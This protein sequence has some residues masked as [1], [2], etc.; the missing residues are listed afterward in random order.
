MTKKQQLTNFAQEQLGFYVYALRNPID[1]KIFYIGKGQGSRVL[2]H[3]NDVLENPD[4]EDSFKRQTIKAIHDAGR[5]VESFIVQHGLESEDHAFATESAI[6]GTLKLLQDGLDHSQFTLTNK[7][8]PPSFNE[9]GLR[10]LEEVLDDYGQPADSSLIPHNSLLIKSTEAGTWKRGMTRDQVWESIRGWW[11]L[12]R[13]RLEN[14]KYV[15]AIPDFVIR[16]VWEVKPSDW[17]LQMEGDRGWDNVR[18]KQLV[19][20]ERIPRWGLDFGA[21]VSTTRFSSLLSTSVERHFVG[22]ERRANCQY[23]DDRKVK[24]LETK[25]DE[26][27]QTPFCNLNLQ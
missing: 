27:K 10:S 1:N 3:V 6:Y 23:L 18:E 13:K 24:H 17:R 5:E 19:G 26:S 7:V 15:I 16:G 11:H 25:K 22:Q 21:D 2:A 12:D 9:K 14:I 20:K 8:A 4:G